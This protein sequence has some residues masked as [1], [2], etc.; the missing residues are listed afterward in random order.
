MPYN[1]QQISPID[2]Q[3]SVGVGVSL[4]FNG[5]SCFNT[6]FTTQE[7]I[8]SN[9]INWF[10]TNKGERPLNPNF[11]GNLRQFIF[12]QISE[13]TLE[14]LQEDINSQLATYFPGVIVDDLEVTA[15]PDINTINV[16][17]QYQVQNTNISDT[18]NITFD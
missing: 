3:P 7:A 9:L 12:Q 15:Q 10:L 18:L 4:P 2:F 17:L 16:V 5:P 13:D 1:A 6:S 14:F 11:G 8:K